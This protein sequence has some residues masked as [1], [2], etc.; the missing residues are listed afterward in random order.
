MCRIIIIIKI[1][2]TS[3]ALHGP[4]SQLRLLF[5]LFR[6]IVPGPSDRSQNQYKNLRGLIYKSF[7]LSKCTLDNK[8]SERAKIHATNLIHSCPKKGEVTRSALIS[9][10]FLLG[11]HILNIAWIGLAVFQKEATCI[12][13]PLHK[14]GCNIRDIIHAT[15]VFYSI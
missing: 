10:D 12:G 15:A 7:L 8:K 11:A 3:A 14:S 2:A 5:T 13:R 9:S 1:R 6:Q 4:I